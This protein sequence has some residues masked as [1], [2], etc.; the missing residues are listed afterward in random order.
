MQEGQLECS[1]Y[2]KNLKR[3]AKWKNNQF[4][5]EFKEAKTEMV[6]TPP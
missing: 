2:K 4:Y 5:T 6:W 3:Q 1:D